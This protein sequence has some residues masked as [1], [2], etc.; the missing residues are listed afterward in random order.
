MTT[1]SSNPYAAIS[2]A[3]ITYDDEGGT[4]AQQKVAMSNDLAS[5]PAS[6]EGPWSLMWGPA[7]N[8][9]IL[10]FV[11]LN[12]DKTRY[13]VAVRGSLSDE[14]APG[15]IANWFDDFDALV[16]VPWLYPQTVGGALISS[17]MNDALALLMGATD[18]ATDLTLIDYLRMVLVGANAGLMVTGH[19]LGG[20]LA[21]LVAPW[22]Y[23]QLPKTGTVTG[24]AITPY[25]FAAP[26]AGTDVRAVLRQ[27]L[28][29]RVS[30][31]QHAGYRADGIRQHIGHAGDVP[32]AEP[33]ALGVQPI[34]VRNPRD[35]KGLHAR[36]WRHVFA[37]QPEG[38]G[39]HGLLL[40]AGPI[41]PELCLRGRGAARSRRLPRP[42]DAVLAES[43]SLQRATPAI[44]DRRFDWRSV[45]ELDEPRR[46]PR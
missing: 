19:S 6:A 4:L 13:A 43:L 44:S 12:A 15:F 8:D 29:G 39:N 2:L 31:C 34:P 18:P 26:T 40:G 1:T 37:D 28:P 20:A 16:Q 27:P 41:R 38:R 25:T 5:L 9:G 35:S 23:D 21:S 45:T 24:V 46:G 30:L 14:D 17:G 10:A 7:A 3:T 32:V 11:A 42:R 22:L 36:R 33:D